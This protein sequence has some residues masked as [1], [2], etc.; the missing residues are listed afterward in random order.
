MLCR[1]GD[2]GSLAK[3]QMSEYAECALFEQSIADEH[4]SVQYLKP[5]G[6][7]LVA[8]HPKQD[9]TLDIP[10]NP[11]TDSLERA[12]INLHQSMVSAYRMGEKYDEWFTACFGFNTTLL[13][14]GPERRP[15]LG[16]FSPRNKVEADAPTAQKGWLSSVSSYVFGNQKEEDPDWLTFTDMAPLMLTT[17]ASLTNVRARLQSGEVD[18]VKFRPNVV[19]TGEGEFDEDY[20]AEMSINGQ[21]G[22]SLTKLCNRCVS[23]N[24]NYETGRFETSGDG[25]VLKHL[26]KDRRV[27]PGN[28]WSPAFGRYAFL[29][30]GVDG[31][32]LAVGD[33]VQVTRRTT[34]RPKWDWPLKSK[35]AGRYY[36]YS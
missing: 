22:F 1:V 26:T 10:L 20:W 31:V 25:A 6:E 4:V 35:G 29:A 16:T 18:M 12:E 34:E 21:P 15:V 30:D 27:D 32:D 2:D 9:E 23:L 33:E 13:Y 36:N 7:P 19:V 8:P 3:M 5:K 11:A 17:E 14:I 28:K 24:I